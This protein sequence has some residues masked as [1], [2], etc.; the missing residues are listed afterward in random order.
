MGQLE[1]GA[2]C[3]RVLSHLMA[4]SK[5][6]AENLQAAARPAFP[7]EQRLVTQ[8]IAGLDSFAPLVELH[9]IGDLHQ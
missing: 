4:G 9:Q 7:L 3:R 1:N 5:D 6:N 8:R 2:R